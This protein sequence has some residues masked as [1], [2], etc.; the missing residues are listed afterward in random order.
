MSTTD[1]EAQAYDL[2]TLAEARL[3]EA[4]IC[5]AQDRPEA[6]T[7]A[8]LAAR[9][10]VADAHEALQRVDPWHGLTALYRERTALFA[11]RARGGVR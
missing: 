4:C 11:A 7:V 9:R 5:A 6:R 1:P 8:L 2:V 3:L 10:A